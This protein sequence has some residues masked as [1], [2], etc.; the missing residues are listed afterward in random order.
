MLLNSTGSSAGAQQL[1]GGRRRCSAA[2]PAVGGLAVTGVVSR[3]T[4]APNAFAVLYPPPAA[5]C[6]SRVHRGALTRA[7]ATASAVSEGP[8]SVTNAPEDFG[9]VIAGA[10]ISGLTLALGLLKKGVKVQVLERDV[11]A[12]RGE[13]KIRGPIQVGAPGLGRGSET[14]RRKLNNTARQQRAR[15]RRRPAQHTARASPRTRRGAQ[16]R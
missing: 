6:S 14:S 10:G 11:T 2:A 8:R 16:A 12:I 5:P 15:E 4:T 1:R 7:S 3:P 13:G 9:V